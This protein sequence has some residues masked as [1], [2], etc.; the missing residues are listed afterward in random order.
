[1]AKQAELGRALCRAGIPMRVVQAILAEL[2]ADPGE[3]PR[4]ALSP[5]ELQLVGRFITALRELL[6]EDEAIS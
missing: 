5:T 4:R 6:C 3:K 1:M 2:P